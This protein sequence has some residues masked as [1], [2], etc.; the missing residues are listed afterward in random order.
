MNKFTSHFVIKIGGQNVPENLYDDLEEVIVDTSLQLPGMFSIRLHDPGLSWV[1]NSLFEIGK[2]VEIS[3][4]IDEEAASDRSKQ[5][6]QSLIKGEITALEPHFTA[7][8]NTTMEIRGYDKLHRLHRGRKTRTFLKK[9]DSDIARTMAQEA[10]LSAN[11]DATT[12]T[13]D[14]LIQYNQTNMEFLMARAERIGYQVFVSNGKLFFKKGD[15]SPSG[16]GPELVYLEDLISFEPRWTASHQADK[17]SVKG[18]DP[19][20]KQ[21]ITGQSTP[22]SS[23]NQGGMTGTGGSIA[24]SAFSSAEEIIADRPVLTNDEANSIATGLSNDISREFVQ[25]EGSCFG[26]PGISAGCKI[27][28][29]G[30]GTRFSG[31]YFVTSANHVYNIKGYMTHFSIAGR[32]PNTLSSLLQTNSGNKSEQGLVPGM[33]TG[34]VTNLNDPDN[35]GR[36]KVK[37]AW[38]GDVESTWAR[39]S[40]PMAG[41]ERGWMILPEVNDEVLVAFEQGDIHHPYILG[42]LW[43]SK[44]KPPKPNNEVFKGGKVNERILKSRSGHMIILDDT[45]GKEQII[46]Q[47]KTSKNK[48]VINSKDNTITISVD[49]DLSSNAKGATTIQSTG[50]ITLKSMDDL[51]IECKNFEVNAQ[52]NA[53]VKANVGVNVQNA[54]AKIALSG[55]TVNINNGALEVM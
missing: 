34:L 4:V 36:V 35:L 9:T 27:T 20:R 31:K 15:S 30:I 6:P 11:V 12:V 16:T 2:E 53:N 32:H 41:A 17:M 55:P 5:A 14:Y 33:V 51:S 3:A 40:A 47:D 44:D 23:V 19:V 45:D 1:D 48:I 54:A 50:K 38:L 43:N 29:K 37:Y 52:M 25:A 49:K 46:I 18:W 24:Q 28:I 8:G 10:G 22:N 42:A 13:H 21:A 26:H 7:D 39:M